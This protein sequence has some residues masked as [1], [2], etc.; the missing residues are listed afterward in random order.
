LYIDNF[1]PEKSEKNPFGYFTQ[2]IFFSFLRRIAKE[3]KQQYTKYMYAEDVNNMMNDQ[4]YQSHDKKPFNQ[5]QKYNEWSRDHVRHFIESFEIAKQKKKEKSESKK[6]EREA[7]E[8]N[9]SN[10]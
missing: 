10:H 7:D 3:K 1:K 8:I 6:K 4:V 9:T 2:I 5:N